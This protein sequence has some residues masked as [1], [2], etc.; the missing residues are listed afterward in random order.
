MR[1]DAQNGVRT[2]SMALNNAIGLPLDTELDLSTSVPDDAVS[3]VDPV[4]LIREA[5]ASRPEVKALNLRQKAS[6]AA[7]GVAGA[8]KFPQ[9]FLSGNYTFARPNSRIF[10][11]QDRFNGTWD[12]GVGILFTLW[13]W[14]SADHQIRQARAQAEKAKDA[15]ASLQDAVRLDVRDAALTLGEAAEKIAT[16]ETCVRQAQE[17][18]RVSRESFREGLVLSSEVLDAE[19]ALLQAALQRTQARV[20]AAMAQAALDRAVG[21]Q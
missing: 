16:A 5:L 14:N 18:L 19:V 17:N 12:V 21:R 6:E 20:D 3:A 13:D 11:A 4:S 10:P 15:L 9:I 8:D 1:I 2:A 7:V